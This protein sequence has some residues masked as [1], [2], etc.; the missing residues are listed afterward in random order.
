MTYSKSPI[1]PTVRQVYPANT[2][3]WLRDIRTL[4]PEPVRPLSLWRVLLW[5]G[6]GWSAIFAA[7]WGVL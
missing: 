6:L 7:V 1:V 5:V 4:P 2:E 3:A